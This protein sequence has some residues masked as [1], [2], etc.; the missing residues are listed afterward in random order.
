LDEKILIYLNQLGS[1]RWDAFW[2]TVTN[3][4]TWWWLYLL[5]GALIIWKYGWKKG[6]TVLVLL[7]IAVTLN[8]QFIN[9]V[10]NTTARLRPCNEPAL[11]D[12]LRIL[13]CSTQYSFFSG[14]AGNS[15]L[16]AT[17]YWRIMKGKISRLFLGLLFIWAAMLAY[18]R[19]YVGVHYPSDVIVGTLE[20]LTAGF[21][22]GDLIRRFVQ[23]IDKNK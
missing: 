6:L 11:Q 9:F 21:L 18:S 23:K 8:D 13:K 2:L 5:L 14:H 20:G 15:F 19:I 22:A 12:K 4:H 10:K 7:V 16:L 3:Q 1:P 17:A